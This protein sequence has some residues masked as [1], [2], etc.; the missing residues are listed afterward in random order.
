MNAIYLVQYLIFRG[1]FLYLHT[2]IDSCF[3][4]ILFCC[5]YVMLNRKTLLPD[6]FLI[7]IKL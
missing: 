6:F 7:P 4:S 3:D 5:K 2:F 1:V